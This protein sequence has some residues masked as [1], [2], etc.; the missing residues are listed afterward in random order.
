VY[1]QAEIKGDRALGARS[2]GVESSPMRSTVHPLR[3]RSAPSFLDLPDDLLERVV[4]IYGVSK[5]RT[6]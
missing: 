4:V 5:A 6:P 3:H 2:Q 1:T